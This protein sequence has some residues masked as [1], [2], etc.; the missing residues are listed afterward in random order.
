LTGLLTRWR[1]NGKQADMSNGDDNPDS[2]PLRRGV[3]LAGGLGTRLAPLTT[4]VSKHLL[5]IYDKPLIYYPLST[6]MLAGVREVALITTS[7]QRPLYEALFGDG[8]A[9]GMRMV[10]R[11][12]DEPRGIADALLTAED[13]IGGEA[14]VLA[15]GDNVLHSAGLM[16]ELRNAARRRS[17]AVCFA[18]PVR[19]PGEF[20]V[21]EFDDEGRAVGL[22]EK[23]E[24]P[25]SD[26]AVTGFYFYDG[27][28]CS[29][30]RE[31]TPSAR[32]E[33][34]ITDL[35]RLYLERGEL[36]VVRLPRGATWLDT[37][38]LD[39]L[40]GASE[41]VRATERQNDFKV[42]C[43][44]ELAWRNHWISTEDL[45]RLANRYSNSYGDY[46]AMLAAEDRRE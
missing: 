37:G 33:L 31:L 24:H 17:G 13:F 2:G 14:S 43:P 10:Y 25:R 45:T 23:P 22:E 30:A 38:T 29:L 3:L 26:W 39:G 11:L 34:E 4:A 20:G 5:P 42:A 7:S 8:E 41:W 36:T 19:N 1:L 27:K 15:L 46:L 12:Q 6:L 18:Y 9:L 21:V 40:I 44:E 28:A 35:N 16:Q 32:G